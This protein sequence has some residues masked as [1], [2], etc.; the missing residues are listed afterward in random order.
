MAKQYFSDSFSYLRFL[1][2]HTFFDQKTFHAAQSF[3][4]KSCILMLIGLI[5]PNY[6]LVLSFT[7]M[8]WQM[9]LVRFSEAPR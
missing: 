1:L 3:G 2:A 5:T 6:L 7:V 8:E 4:V 9:Q